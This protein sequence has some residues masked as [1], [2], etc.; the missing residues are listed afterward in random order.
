MDYAEQRLP[1][2]IYFIW[3]R[4]SKHNNANK[5]AD[6]MRRRKYLSLQMYE[7]EKKQVLYGYPGA[8]FE[9]DEKPKRG[10]LENEIFLLRGVNEMGW[11]G[12]GAF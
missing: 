9:A 7:L 10:P 5:C 11:R 6:L 8:D 3:I 2:E 12:S 4:M 1:C